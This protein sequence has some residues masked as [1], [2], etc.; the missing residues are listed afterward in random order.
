[1]TNP[2]K[3]PP[4]LCLKSTMKRKKFAKLLVKFKKL[5]K[6]LITTF[7]FKKLKRNKQNMLKGSS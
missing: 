7:S 5:K 4:F 2:L 1:M 6:D 3:D